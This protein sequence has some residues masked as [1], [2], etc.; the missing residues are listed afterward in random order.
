MGNDFGWAVQSLKEGKHVQRKGWNG[1]GMF[2]FY[3]S[4]VAHG[5]ETVTYKIS[6]SGE[7]YPLQPFIMM[8]TADNMTVPWL[9]SQTDLLAED[10]EENFEQVEYSGQQKWNF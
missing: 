1:K 10:W 5:V 3:F 8:K 6:E 7:T 4:P 9:A 2:L